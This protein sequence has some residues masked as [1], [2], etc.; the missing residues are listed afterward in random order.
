MAINQSHVRDFFIYSETPS[1]NMETLLLS[2]VQGIWSS[3]ENK[4]N[5][6][7]KSE[8]VFINEYSNHFDLF[9]SELVIGSFKRQVKVHENVFQAQQT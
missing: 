8:I 9:I 7:F 1:R 6:K 5:F 3:A 4:N 2:K